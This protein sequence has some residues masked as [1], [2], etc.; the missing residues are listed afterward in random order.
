MKT[1]TY[2]FKSKELILKI[3]QDMKQQHTSE[4]EILQLIP[5]L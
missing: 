2:Y 5:D 4:L 3:T 1:T